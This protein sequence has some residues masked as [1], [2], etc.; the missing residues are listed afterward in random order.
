MFRTAIAVCFVAFAGCAGAG[1]P[2]P[3]QGKDCCGSAAMSGTLNEDGCYPYCE[4]GQETLTSSPVPPGVYA[5]AATI[6][7]HVGSTLGGCYPMYGRLYVTL[8]FDSSGMP[9]DGG[10]ITLEAGSPADYRFHSVA[11]DLGGPTTT[12][13]EDRDYALVFATSFADASGRVTYARNAEAT[14]RTG[15]SGYVFDVAYHRQ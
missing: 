11:T 9:S 2:E 4:G 12:E 14:A 15:C 8:T 13:R 7:G 6:I 10:A 5:G 3:G 1:T